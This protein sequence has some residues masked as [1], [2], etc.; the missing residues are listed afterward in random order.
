MMEQAEV[1]RV[2]S[3]N[4]TMVELSSGKKFPAWN[5]SGEAFEVGQ[6]VMVEPRARVIAPTESQ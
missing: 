6:V 3:P 4:K 2:L 5:P 1:V